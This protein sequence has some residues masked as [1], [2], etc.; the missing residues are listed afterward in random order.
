[1]NT[2]SDHIEIQPCEQNHRP[3]GVTIIAVL[4]LLA[5]GTLAVSHGT[6][7][8][9][10]LVEPSGSVS[11]SR[12]WLVAKPT[13]AFLAVVAIAAC[14]G[15]LLGSKWGWT[16]ASIYWA[17]RLSRQILRLGI[18]VVAGV[19]ASEFGGLSG[20]LAIVS[21]LAFCL[22]IFLYLFSDEV[23]VHFSLKAGNRIVTLIVIG[24]LGMVPALVYELA[25]AVEQMPPGLE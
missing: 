12:S 8:R 20:V 19:P 7:L 5:G 6:L 23:W 21:Q 2:D 14:V 17:W 22:L 11:F 18:I 10:I 3:I 9:H 16:S 1:M 13:E 4:C 15:M 24:C 25:I